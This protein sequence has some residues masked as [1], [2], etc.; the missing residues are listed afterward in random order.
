MLN[1]E[2]EIFIHYDSFTFFYINLSA[3]EEE[4]TIDI[5]LMSGFLSASNLFFDEL[6]LSSDNLFRVLRGNC[7][8]RM[9]LGEHVHGTLLLKN[10]TNLDLKTYYELDVLTR[11]IIHEFETHYLQEIRLFMDT[12]RYEFQGIKEFIMKEV[13]KMKAHMYSSYLI[14][15]LA[16]AINQ[17]VKKKQ[18]RDLL[19]SINRMFSDLPLNYQEIQDNL[20]SIRQKIIEFKEKHI[21]FA[22]IIEKINNESNQIWDLFQVPIIE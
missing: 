18:S 7:E 13:Q 10:L 20:D 21:T 22:K 15:I 14:Q 4:P 3:P 1:G 12:G 2:I 17:N 5:Q 19:I 9:C 16:S 6:G 8:I 11:S